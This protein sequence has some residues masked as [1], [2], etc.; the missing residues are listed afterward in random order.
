MSHPQTSPT[1]RVTALVRRIADDPTVTQLVSLA[2]GGT[3]D[4]VHGREAILAA[5]GQRLARGERIELVPSVEVVPAGGAEVQAM[6]AAAAFHDPGARH[7]LALAP[8]LASPQDAHLLG[9]R[10]DRPAQRMARPAYA[11]FL[12]VEA[13]DLRGAEDGGVWRW[14]AS[15]RT[16]RWAPAEGAPWAQR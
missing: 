2:F 13:R 16:V 8:S 7:Q 4:V 11:A 14:Y 15:D 12:G 10:I 5:L 3:D 1:T 6:R 9:L